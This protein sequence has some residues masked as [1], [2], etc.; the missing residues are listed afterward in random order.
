MEENTDPVVR[1]GVVRLGSSECVRRLRGEL[2]PRSADAGAVG[3][4]GE[5]VVASFWLA[6]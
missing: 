1:R 2:S 6:G 3:L 5:E 4:G